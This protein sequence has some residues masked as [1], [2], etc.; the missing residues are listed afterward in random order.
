MK[1]EEVEAKVNYKFEILFSKTVL[2]DFDLKITEAPKHRN[3]K[4]GDDLVKAKKKEKGKKLIELIMID[5]G[6]GVSHEEAQSKMLS[7]GIHA[8]GIH[9]ALHFTMCLEH[10]SNT[11]FRVVFL[12]DVMKEM[13]VDFIPVLSKYKKAFN[14]YMN[15]RD[16]IPEMNVY[17]MGYRTMNQ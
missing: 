7:R 2:I 8:A 4:R 17:F 5:L 13:N 16:S 1:Q 11:E 3:L 14:L 6:P 12:R 9:E 10:F 15:F